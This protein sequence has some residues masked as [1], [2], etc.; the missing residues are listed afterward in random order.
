MG[1]VLLSLISHVENCVSNHRENEK[2]SRQIST[3]NIRCKILTFTLFVKFYI[4]L[5]LIL[6]YIVLIYHFFGSIRHYNYRTIR[7]FTISHVIYI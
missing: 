3:A 7:N 1:Q 4:N 6:Y 2:Y 5:Y